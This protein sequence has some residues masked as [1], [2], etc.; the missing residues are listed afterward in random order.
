MHLQLRIVQVTVHAARQCGPLARDYDPFRLRPRHHEPGDQHRR[1]R[2]HLV[3]HRQRAEPFR[4]VVQRRV[5][6]F[7]QRHARRPGLA[8]HVHRVRPV[9]QRRL[10]RRILRAGLQRPHPEPRK[11]APQPRRPIVVTRHLRVTVRRIVHAQLRICE[12]TAHVVGQPRPHAAHQRRLARPTGVGHA[13]D[14]RRIARPGRPAHRQRAQLRAGDATAKT[15]KHRR[16]HHRAPPRASITSKECHASTLSTFFH[17]QT[18]GASSADR[19]SQPSHK[20]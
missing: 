1:A 12:V 6:D 10:E 4:R 14:H 18:S 15:A 7:R 16:H 8:C 17:R 5:V 2:P 13:D 11:L 19:F 20:E 3:A 9:R